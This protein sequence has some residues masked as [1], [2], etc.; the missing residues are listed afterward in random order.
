MDSIVCATRNKNKVGEIKEILKDIPVSIVSLEDIGIDVEVVEDGETFEENA[1]KKA[2]EIMKITGLPT[3]ADDSGLEVDAL[4]GK[5]GVYSA[6]FG[7]VHGDYKNNN[8]KLLEL[9]EGIPYEKRGARFVTV[10]VLLYP[11]GR[12]VK[13][14]GEIKGFIGNEP[15]GDNGFGYDP[16]F[17]VPEYNMSFAELGSDIKNKISHRGRALEELKKRL[18]HSI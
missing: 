1:Q 9:M 14:R 12:S 15:K 7:G 3:L 8:D 11:D 2:M 13:A 6:R 4:D 16:I 17:V 18:Y 5:P 10:I